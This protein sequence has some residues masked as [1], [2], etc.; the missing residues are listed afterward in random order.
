[1]GLRKPG[2]HGRLDRS[3][4]VDDGCSCQAAEAGL[5]DAVGSR[6]EVALRR[7]LAGHHACG[8]LRLRWVLCGCYEGRRQL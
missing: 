1:M 4:S 2:C 6:I 5:A 8:H 3:A 7:M